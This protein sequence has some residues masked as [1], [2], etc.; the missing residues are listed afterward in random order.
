MPDKENDHAVT[1]T[2]LLKALKVSILWKIIK[3]E[4]VINV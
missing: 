1:P 4:L 3:I 2:G